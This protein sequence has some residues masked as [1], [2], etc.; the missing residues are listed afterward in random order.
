MTS[1][2]RLPLYAVLDVDRDADSEAIRDAYRQTVKEYHPDVFDHEDAQDLFVWATRARDVLTDETR[3]QRYDRVGHA[4][5][6]E[7]EGWASSA[8]PAARAA[9]VY[10]PGDERS[11]AA[12]A[13]SSSGDEERATASSTDGTGGTASA[14]ARARTGASASR[15]AEAGRTSAT[16]SGDRSGSAGSARRGTTTESTRGTAQSTGGAAGAAGFAEATQRG[17][18]AAPGGAAE[19]SHEEFTAQE[20]LGPHHHAE[21]LY[22]RNIGQVDAD[23]GS[24]RS[25]LGSLVAPILGVGFS[26][27][28]LFGS[29]AMILYAL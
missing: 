1:R 11:T 15:T 17:N 8:C 23:W 12:D 26:L 21:E 10:W 13:R 6:V 24:G 22:F 4:S 7:G 2:C 20:G 28:V 3:R 9:A 18:S 25:G 16:D 27:V 14:G 19:W 29:F 5:F